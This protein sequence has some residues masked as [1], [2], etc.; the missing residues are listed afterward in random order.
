MTEVLRQ[1]L[2][3]LQERGKLPTVNPILYVQ[4]DN[5]EENKNKNKSVFAFCADL[6]EKHVFEQVYVGF[7]MVGHTH[8][9]IDQFF[10][11]ISAWLKKMGHNLC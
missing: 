4:L 10:S 6:V 9:D 5:C 11:T 8:E 2:L 3:D 7:L 1:T